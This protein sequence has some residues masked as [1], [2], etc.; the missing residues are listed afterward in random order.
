VAEEP[1]A[2]GAIGVEIHG[3][4]QLLLSFAGG[5]EGFEH[6]LADGHKL[7]GEEGLQQVV[8]QLGGVSLRA[9]LEAAR[10]VA[11]MALRPVTEEPVEEEEEEEEAT[12]L[13]AD[14]NT[15]LLLRGR[16]LALPPGLP[17]RPDLF[18]FHHVTLSGPGE[19]RAANGDQMTLILIDHTLLD[20]LWTEAPAA[21]ATHLLRAVRQV[22]ARVLGPLGHVL[23]DVL[24]RLEA[25]DPEHPPAASERSTL[26]DY[27]VLAMAT[28]LVYWSGG[29]V[30]DLDERFFPLL[31]LTDEPLPEE[32]LESQL[33]DIDGLGVLSAMAEVLPYSVPEGSM[34]DS[35]GDDEL[36]PLAKWGVTRG[37][38]GEESYEGSL[39]LVDAARLADLVQR[40]DSQRFVER[41]EEFRETWYRLRTAG[42]GR[43][44][45]AHEAELALFFWRLE[46]LRMFLA[47]AGVN[48]LRPAL[49]FYA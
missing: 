37:A 13:V 7:T 24:M 41:T 1:E 6:E 3:Q 29:T 20:H 5:L 44:A 46:E 8:R 31:G 2:P 16:V 30:E 19:P 4:G 25:L 18:S 14:A 21:Q 11:E 10:P 28:A 27:E 36:S 42:G 45:T 38:D 47:I 9:L 23:P 26:M 12:D 49:F 22:Q 48:R 35:F 40:F 33:D 39:F 34:L 15:R 43:P 17:R 32:A